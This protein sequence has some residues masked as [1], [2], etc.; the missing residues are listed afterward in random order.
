MSGGR[1][2][3]IDGTH[4]RRHRW[5][6]DI[7]CTRMAP[8]SRSQ[9]SLVRRRTWSANR[10]DSQHRT[11]GLRRSPGASLRRPGRGTLDTP[12]SLA[13]GL[14][15]FATLSDRHA[16]DTCDD[17]RE[18]ATSTTHVK[19]SG[20]RR[21]WPPVPARWNVDWVPAVA[22][23]LSA[24]LVSQCLDSTLEQALNPWIITRC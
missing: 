6:R 24:S 7:H 17:S 13:R 1:E 9:W 14:P 23:S 19:K 8:S 21:T 15:F 18:P 3:G 2:S 5:H 12:S 10:P 22:V 20:R 4:W 16:V 11:E